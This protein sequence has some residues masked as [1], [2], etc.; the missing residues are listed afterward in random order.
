MNEIT[1]NDKKSNVNLGYIF[2]ETLF[3]ICFKEFMFARVFILFRF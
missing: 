2:N 3:S 1:E